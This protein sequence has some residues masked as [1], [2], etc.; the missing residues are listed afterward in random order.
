MA[1]QPFSP[2]K[3]SAQPAVGSHILIVGGTSV[4]EKLDHD[5]YPLNFLDAAFYRAKAFEDGGKVVMIM[6]TPSYEA[7]VR[8]QEKEHERIVG[9]SFLRSM[10]GRCKPLQ[11][12][13]NYLNDDSSIVQ[14]TP[15]L[16]PKN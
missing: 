14:G 12:G 1:N 16:T 4:N 2:A 6:F 11:T 5:K 8:D 15:Y 10:L 3:P 7:R 13:A 9:C